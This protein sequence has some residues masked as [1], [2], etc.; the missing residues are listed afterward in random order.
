MNRIINSFA[1]VALLALLLASCQAPPTNVADVRKYL[2]ETRPK[3][4]TAFNTKD[5]PALVAFY[6]PDATVL[7]PNSGPVSGHQNI[8]AMY[9]EM[10]NA[11]SNLSIAST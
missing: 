8:E 9:K 2:D 10:V 3:W 11:G 5:V 6:G 7:P 4:R 1:L